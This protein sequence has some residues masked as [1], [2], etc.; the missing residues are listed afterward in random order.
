MPAQQKGPVSMGKN[1]GCR[2]KSPGAVALS[3][4][5]GVLAVV[6][7][8]ASCST[9]RK[10][11]SAF[12]G[13]LPIDVTVADAAN[14]NSPIAVDILV[15]YDARLVDKLVEMPASE[16]FSKKQ[17]FIADHPRVVLQSW[18]W[19]PGQRIEPFK[20]RYGSGARNVV[21]FADYRTEGPHRKVIGAPK[22]IRIVLG[23]RDVT[24]EV[25]Q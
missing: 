17:Q 8:L 18:E 10:V 4:C 21:L 14:D 24:V 23:E 1:L 12:G 2:R 7:F 3:Q 15:V 9:G 19:V 16:W 25:A 6:V 11:R 20:V 13:Q 22:P 5:F